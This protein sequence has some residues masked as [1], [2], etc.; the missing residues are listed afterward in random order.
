[1]FSGVQTSSTLTWPA[2]HLLPMILLI[3]LRHAAFSFSKLIEVFVIQY[4]GLLIYSKIHPFEVYIS[5]NFDNIA[6]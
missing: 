1:M 3:P 5:V 4:Q 2:H 6:L